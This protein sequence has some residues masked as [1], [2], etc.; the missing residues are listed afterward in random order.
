MKSCKY[1]LAING[2]DT[3]YETLLSNI[4][5]V[6]EEGRRKAFRAINGILVQTYWEIGRRILEFEHSNGEKAEYGSGLFEKIA[7]DLRMRC[8]KGFSRSNVI[9]MRLLYMKYPKNQTLS[10][11]LAW[12]HYTEL[13]AIE[14]D[15]E[16]RFYE[17]QCIADGWS[18]RELR[19]QIESALF[20]RIALS[21]DR[22]GVLEL[23]KK[24]IVVRRAEDIV[25]EPYVLEFL[26]LPENYRCSERG[27]EQ[28]LIDNMQKFL[29]E[30]GRGFTFVGRQFRMTIGNTHY[31]VD[32]VFYHRILRC[33]VLIDLKI[34]K[35]SHMDVGQMNMYL[36]YF[37]SEENSEGDVDPIGIVLAAKKND[38]EVEYALGGISNKLFVSRYKLFLPDKKELETE[39]K[40]LLE[41]AG[42][43]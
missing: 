16:R 23:S 24:G 28:G 17:K 10:D 25:K 18:V 26:N 13:L 42:N 12:S 33:F 37:K 35:V 11:Q 32:L 1:P 14:D 4:S 22:K 5:T 2:S 40:S 19:R 6:L 36:N 7:H 8:G 39:L 43:L 20:H 3:D 27:L 30:L 41:G 9:Y 21:K 31:Y 15:M 29:L 34:G 38:V